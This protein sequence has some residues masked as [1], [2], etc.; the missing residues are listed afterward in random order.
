MI[1]HF[2]KGKGLWGDGQ[3]AAFHRGDLGNE[4]SHRVRVEWEAVLPSEK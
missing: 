3:E 2:A 1:A 4:R